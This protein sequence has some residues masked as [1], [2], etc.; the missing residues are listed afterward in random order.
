MTHRTGGFRAK[1]RKKLRKKPRSKGKVSMT[2]LLQSFKIG[3]RV[4]INQEAAVHKAMPH[5]KFKSRTGVVVKKQGK[6]YMVR[7]TD[8][9]KVKHALAAPVHLIKAK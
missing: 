8:G 2:R 5:P 1:T 7:F 3:D 9:G 6:A 4:V